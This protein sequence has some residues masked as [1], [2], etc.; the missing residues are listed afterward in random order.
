MQLKFVKRKGGLFS[1]RMGKMCQTFILYQSQK[2]MALIEA[3]VSIVVLSLGGLALVGIQ[4]RT[5][6]DTQ[7]GVYRAQAIR[8]IND[9]SER[10]KVSP[11]SLMRLNSYQSN[12]GQRG[13]ANPSPDCRAVACNA[14]QLAQYD[15]QSWKRSLEI[16]LPNGRAQIQLARSE[17]ISS[18][19]ARLLAVMV[20]WRQNER[21]GEGLSASE[22][23]QFTEPFK[24][25]N[26][27]SADACPAGWTCHFQYISP[28][29]RCVP[30]AAGR[31]TISG[32]T[33]TPVYCPQ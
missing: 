5:L 4:L 30:R 22:N 27:Y 14:E 8:L 2:G 31:I 21:K 16:A 15:I 20:G 28:V 10:M 19:N 25:N 18:H 3:L 1:S 12:W 7:N 6:A 26:G 33:T 24:I 13:V 9:L 29:Q 23:K 17:N 11:D 32:V